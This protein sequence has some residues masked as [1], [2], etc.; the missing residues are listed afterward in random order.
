MAKVA[1]LIGVS[2][3][4]VGLA[5]LPAAVK[6]VVALERILKDSEMGDFDEVKILT[7]PEPQAM[8]YEVETL[9]S[10]RSKDD[11]VLLFFSG[12]G[13]KDDS[14]NLY[15]ATRITKK[16]AKGD[17]IRSTAVPARFVHEVMNNSRAKR[18]VIILDCCYSG[19][20][21]PNLL[22]KDDGSVDLLGQLGAEGRVVLTSSSSTQYSFEQQ[23]SDLSLYTRYLIEGIETGAGDLDED[24][25]ISVREL[26]EY[27]TSKV[28]ETAPN[29]TPKLITLK[30]LGFDLVLAKAKVTD[31]KLRYRRQVARYN[32]R[33][34]ISSIGRTI[35]DKL[36][37]QLGLSSQ[38][39]NAIETEV[40]YRD[41]ERLENIQLYQDEFSK[42]INHEYP[43]SSHSLSELE[44]L[45]DVLGLSHE[46][47]VDEIKKKVISQSEYRQKMEAELQKRNQYRKIRS[48]ISTIMG[49]IGVGVFG[50]FMFSIWG[51]YGRTINF[52]CVCQS[53][54]GCDQFKLSGQIYY[55]WKKGERSPDIPY[56]TARKEFVQERVVELEKLGFVCPTELY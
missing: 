27:A 46:D 48:K 35:L 23:G 17:L 16:S 51:Y 14:N 42:A 34:I 40:L 5:P 21:D 31:P 7:N 54:L 12:H 25:K 52:T 49:I 19:A 53:P 29:M 50:V 28:Q 33:G 24:G 41:K 43:L 56:T 8:Q 9:F 37:I 38:I 55:R 22:S 18:Q 30:D 11:F 4:A 47:V 26:H 20:F 36:Q 39:A 10:G 15:F 44:N 2:K 3:Y 32:S 1:L 45:L 6:D 13:I